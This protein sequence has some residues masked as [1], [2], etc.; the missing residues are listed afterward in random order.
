MKTK[1]KNFKNKN[2]KKSIL[3]IDDDFSI[4]TLLE[5]IL[6]NEYQVYCFPNGYDAL[7]WIESNDIPDLV[8]VDVQMPVLNGLQFIKSLNTSGYYNEIPIIV[9][10]GLD[11]T[12]TKKKCT[13]TGAIEFFLKPFDPNKLLNSINRILHKIYRSDYV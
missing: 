10:S 5:I 3:V 4:R 7:V 9:L 13:E 6:K 12:E 11:D 8:I 2:P 1:R